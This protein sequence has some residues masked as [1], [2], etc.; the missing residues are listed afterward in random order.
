M[1]DANQKFLFPEALLRGRVYQEMGC[2]W[3]EEPMMPHEMREF[4]ALA[5]AL[6]MRIATGEN[7]YGKY[8]F[9]DLLRN[10]GA[11]VVQPDNR[12]AGGVSEWMEIGAIADA[13][14][15]ELASHGGRPDEYAYAAGDAECDLYRVGEF[16]ERYFACGDAAAGEWGDSCAGGSGDG[17]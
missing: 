11:D 13:F 8:E 1:V 17:K 10:G 2:F 3:Y 4:G 15:V 14:N 16:E 9:L 7:L 5:Q 6:D 12:R